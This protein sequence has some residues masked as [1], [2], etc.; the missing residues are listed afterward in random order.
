MNLVWTL[1][2]FIPD[3]KFIYGERHSTTLK[4]TTHITL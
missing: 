2:L 4:Q 3:P 1:I